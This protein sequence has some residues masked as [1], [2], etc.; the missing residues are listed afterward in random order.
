MCQSIEWSDCHITREVIHKIISPGEILIR[1][2]YFPPCFY[3]LPLTKMW[4]RT[5]AEHRFPRDDPTW[6][7]GIPK[8]FLACEYLGKWK[9]PFSMEERN[10]GNNGCWI[11]SPVTTEV[12]IHSATLCTCVAGPQQTHTFNA[13]VKKQIPVN[14]LMK[15]EYRWRLIM[16]TLK[17]LDF[18]S[19]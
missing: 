13:G 16:Y 8:D 3:P 19:N 2:F 4:K 12:Q 1:N 14:T 18:E 10:Q 7:Q 11:K 17:C 9:S 15:K 5:V 6:S